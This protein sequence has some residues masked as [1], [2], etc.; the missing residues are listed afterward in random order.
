MSR[1][2]PLSQL[3]SDATTVPRIVLPFKALAGDNE[4]HAM[5]KRGGS[6]V[7]GSSERYRN[8]LNVCVHLAAS[9]YAHQRGER[10]KGPA[11]MTITLYEPD[12]RHRDI[13][14]YVKMIADSLI[15]SA[16]VDDSQ[17]DELLVLR[18]GRDR[19]NPR[20]E[21]EVRAI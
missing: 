20:A 1:S 3:P 6:R 10:I 21:I 13:G 18:G 15:G 2:I 19:F 9:Q 17:I 11:R 7:I 12:K 4:R 5:L 16:Y 8:C 14:N